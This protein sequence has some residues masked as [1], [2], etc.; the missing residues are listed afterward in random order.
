MAQATSSQFK[1][2]TGCPVPVRGVDIDTDRIIPARFLRCVSFE[3]LG[4]HVFEDDRRDPS[5][6]PSSHS[7][8]DPRYRGAS[9]LL[10][11]RNFGCGSSREH[12]PQALLRWG[13]RAIAGESFAEIFFGNCVALGLPCVTVS[14]EDAEKLMRF[15]EESAGQKVTVDLEK[16]QVAAPTFTITAAMPP[17]LRE[18][19]LRGTWD[20]TGL[21]LDR[22]AEVEAVAGKL[23]YLSAFKITGRTTGQ[24]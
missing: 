7:F 5:G 11:N 10:A 2:V 21:L 1:A 12:A 4:E 3:G 17:G 23:P 16:L 22:Y 20:A 8:N 15:A 24:R 19:F 18:A 6:K 14:H 9:I 13:I